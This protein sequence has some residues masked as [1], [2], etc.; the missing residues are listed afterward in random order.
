MPSRIPVRDALKSKFPKDAEISA[1][2]IPSSYEQRW[3][4]QEDGG[5]IVRVPYIGQPYDTKLFEIEIG[6]WAHTH[7]MLCDDIIPAMTLCYV[8]RV[9]P[10]IELCSTCYL[11]HADSESSK[12]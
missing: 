4:P 12:Q 1:D 8:T 5:L 9:G 2:I 10:Y 11:Q 6:A 3:F 7:C